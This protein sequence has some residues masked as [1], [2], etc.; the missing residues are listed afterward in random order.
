MAMAAGS[1]P[2]VFCLD[3]HQLQRYVEQGLVTPLDE[4]V[5]ACNWHPYRKLPPALLEAT[6]CAGHVYALPYSYTTYALI[7]RKDMFTEAGISRPPETWEELFEDAQRLTRKGTTIQKGW[8][9]GKTEDVWGLH[10]VNGRQAAFFFAP[11]VWQAGGDMIRETPDGWRV[12]FDSPAGVEAL[13]FYK[14]LRW[15]RWERDGAEYE[16]VVFV[17]PGEPWLR[18]GT[19]AMT[20]DNP[21]SYTDFAGSTGGLGMRDIGIAPLPA[22]PAGPADIM[23]GQFLAVNSQIKDPE[24]RQAAW[25]FVEFL[26][27][28]E[29]ARVRTETFVKLGFA[30]SVDPEDLRRFGY[31]DYYEDLDPQWRRMYE[32]A[33]QVA[34]LEPH[35]PGYS[36][37]STSEL[38]VPIESV[39]LPGG[40]SVDVAAALRKCAQR[41]N[42]L[43]LGARDP[44]KRRLFMLMACAVLALGA[45]GSVYALRRYMAAVGNRATNT[46]SVGYTLPANART[47]LVGWLMFL[48]AA[49]LILMW[50]YVPMVRG[51]KIAFYDYS[52]LGEKHFIGLQNFVDIFSQPFFWRI[53]LTTLK[54]VGL[55]LGL[56]FFVPIALAILLSEV[57]R[58]KYAFRTIYYLPAVVS[59]VVML[60]LWKTMIFLPTDTG[61]L[62]QILMGTVN[63]I[64]KW[65]GG[66]LGQDHPLFALGP[67]KWIGSPRL[68]MLCVI[69]PG[70][71]GHAGPGSII[72]I[73][74]LRSI[75]D[76]YYQ[77]AEVEGA[78]FLGK[79]RHVAIPHLI[80]L[81]MINFIGAFIGGVR[82]AQEI[83]VMTE[84]GP[85][86]VTRTLGLEIFYD[87]FVYMKYGYATALGWVMGAMLIGFTI[88]NLQI[89]SRVQF[90][91]AG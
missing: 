63:P 14:R 10:L 6:R 42:T 58:G 44:A 76:D 3:A 22:G 38:V 43:I 55:S 91:R 34:R 86:N 30:S 82:A 35:A 87:A 33:Q 27:G 89:L 9:K 20:I 78:G 75:P 60:I 67:L 56:G 16:G 54:F 47:A 23:T 53:V 79:L 80:P 17:W 40:A 39:L 64:G 52:L 36:V 48:P 8:R 74:A 28:E 31:E 11:F 69:I 83:L 13:E 4:F 51:L 12:A 5:K 81:I 18:R 57:P 49:V 84:G 25:E 73:A 66:L 15:T 50:S 37:I 77:A 65:L 7:Y 2:S 24:E 70:I 1:A 88:W 90:S 62:N 46:G 72:Y 85:M 45:L 68:A 61:V 71:W 21:L 32:Q 41:A 29:A 19:V 59:S 26:C